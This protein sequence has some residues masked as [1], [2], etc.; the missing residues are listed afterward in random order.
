MG[1][2]IYYSDRD[3]VDLIGDVAKVNNEISDI[4]NEYLHDATN[5]LNRIKDT[6]KII[7]KYQSDN[8]GW[9]EEFFSDERKKKLKEL[10]KT[11]NEV[12]EEEIDKEIDKEFEKYIDYLDEKYPEYE[13]DEFYTE[14]EVEKDLKRSYKFETQM[15]ES[16][17]KLEKLVSKLEKL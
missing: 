5:K 3:V 4:V 12:N 1:Y 2:E 8:E 6:I 13:S 9:R 14:S 11:L 10:E 17:E 16:I 15:I 7:N